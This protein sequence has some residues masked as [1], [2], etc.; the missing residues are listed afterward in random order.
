[1]AALAVLVGAIATL[2][3]ALAGG[4]VA[5]LKALKARTSPPQLD[6]HQLDAGLLAW[7]A[8]EVRRLNAE[9]A[10]CRKTGGE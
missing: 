8:D 4:V 1:M 3:T 6:Q 5:I 2:V 7:Y 10:H 9:L